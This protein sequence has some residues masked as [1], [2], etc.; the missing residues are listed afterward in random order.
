MGWGLLPYIWKHD[1]KELFTMGGE[2][3]L[4]FYGAYGS[5]VRV[6]VNTSFELIVKRILLTSRT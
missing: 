3:V 4:N 6:F 2:G 5:V 1:V